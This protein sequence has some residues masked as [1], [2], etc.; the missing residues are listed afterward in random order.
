[1][2]LALVVHALKSSGGVIVHKFCM[3]DVARIGTNR[4][5]AWKYPKEMGLIFALVFKEAGQKQRVRN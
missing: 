3:R 4:W 5:C 2:V 1:M